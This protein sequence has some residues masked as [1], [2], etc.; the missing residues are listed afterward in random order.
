MYTGPVSG[1]QETPGRRPDPDDA[2][3]G[4]RSGGLPAWLLAKSAPPPAPPAGRRRAHFLEKLLAGLARFVEHAF[5]GEAI[6]A[7][8][9]LLQRLDPR[10]KLVGLLG[11]IVAAVL[12]RHLASLLLLLAVVVALVVAS[13]IGVRRF[14]LRAWIFIPLFTLA[15]VLP[16]TTSW[17]TPGK[18]LLTFW[19]DQHIALGPI[20]LP[21]TLAVTDHG[22]AGAARLVLRVTCAVSFS[23]LLT[24]TTRWSDLLKAL[25][26]LRVPRMF[27]FVLAMA[28]RYVFLLLRLAQDMVVAR[29]SRTVGRVSRR[30]ERRFVGAAVGTLFGK[31]QATGEQVYLAMM[32]R[33]YSGEALTLE[34]RRLRAADVAW[35]AAVAVTVG[36]AV[37]L[38]LAV[39]R[40][41]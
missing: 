23:V 5:S 40:G 32:A 7:K 36:V 3:G 15:I 13:R 38:D 9:G 17:V 2:A 8:S 28:Y 21:A 24:L 4:D 26:V 39:R 29:R 31:S 27:V 33:G 35:L 41:F 1:S 16:A 6:S 34:R 11:L 20:H 10:F 25:R 12:V 19:R 18:P 37:W 22:L 30:E 14:V